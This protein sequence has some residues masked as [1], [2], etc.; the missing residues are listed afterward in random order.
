MHTIF[1][2]RLDSADKKLF[3]QAARAAGLPVSEF[4][5]R[6]ARE[7]ALPAKKQAACLS[8]ADDVV[9]SLKAERNPKQ[10]IQAKLAQ[11]NGR[12]R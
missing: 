4:V 11:K 7:K 9:L 1:P 3:R 8:Y 12:H 10:F 6:A 2:I 5:R